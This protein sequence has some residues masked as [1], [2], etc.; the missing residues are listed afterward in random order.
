[1]PRFSVNQLIT[2]RYHHV[3]MASHSP[4]AGSRGRYGSLVFQRHFLCAA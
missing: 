1:M 4:T 2:P 3:I